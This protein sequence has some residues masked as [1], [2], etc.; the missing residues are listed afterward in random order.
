MKLLSIVSTFVFFIQSIPSSQSAQFVVG[1]DGT[2]EDVLNTLTCMLIPCADPELGW[3]N[4]FAPIADPG[5]LQDSAQNLT[6]VA[7]G[8]TEANAVQ[9][10]NGAIALL[11]ALL[12]LGGQGGNRR[13]LRGSNVEADEIIQ[14][15]VV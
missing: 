4:F 2:G 8:E 6:A 13:G 1:P 5:V 12:Q 15:M 10:R 3:R 14:D 7:N 11:N 9:L